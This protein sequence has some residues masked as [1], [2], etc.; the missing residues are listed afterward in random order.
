MSAPLT[1]DDRHALLWFARDGT[2]A[3]GF[4]YSAAQYKVDGL[5]RKGLVEWRQLRHK[6]WDTCLTVEGERIATVLEVMDS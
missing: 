5:V 2:N 4:A 1:E 3:A 6:R